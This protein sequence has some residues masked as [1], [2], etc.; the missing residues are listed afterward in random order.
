MLFLEIRIRLAIAS[1]RLTPE[2]Q[3]SPGYGAAV[4]GA[5]Q[6]TQL[7]PPLDFWAA[8]DAG[9]QRWGGTSS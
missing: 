4:P 8:K 7:W 3:E 9:Q 6:H 2:L 1:G 5:H